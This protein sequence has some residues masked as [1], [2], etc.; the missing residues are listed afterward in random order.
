VNAWSYQKINSMPFWID[1]VILVSHGEYFFVL[2]FMLHNVGSWHLFF[3]KAKQP[4]RKASGFLSFWLE[5]NY[6]VLGLFRV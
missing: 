5:Y 3:T 2:D 6:E 1:D 4:F